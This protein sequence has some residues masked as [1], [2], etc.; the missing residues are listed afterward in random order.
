MAGKVKNESDN[1]EVKQSE[2]IVVDLS[3][4]KQDESVTNLSAEDQEKIK[5]ISEKLREELGLNEQEEKKEEEE[6]DDYYS[7]FYKKYSKK[8]ENVDTTSFGKYDSDLDF[9]INKKVRR[10][11]LPLPKKTKVLFGALAGVF[12]IMFAAVLGVVLYKPPV[13]VYISGVAI[14]QRVDSV[15]GCYVVDDN[16]LGQKLS[17]DSVYINCTYS[18]GSVKKVQITE[19]MTKI[20]TS[21]AINSR[22]EFVREGDV[23]VEVKY[24]GKTMILRFVVEANPPV[25]MTLFS[26]NNNTKTFDISQSATTWQIDN[27]IVV[28]ITYQDGTTKQV[29]VND[30]R[31]LIDGKSPTVSNGIMQIPA[32]LSTGGYVVRISYSETLA[33]GTVVN[34]PYQE[35]NINIVL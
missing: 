16:Y 25:S 20:L 13:P 9:K 1:E 23:D 12:V 30:C 4:D 27:K 18:D 6:A 24:A 7:R 11:H 10:V 33:D 32:G 34:V 28:N 35:F 2:D 26:A 29:S 3:G 19:D 31:Y 8:E 15:D 14:T 5:A 17:Y 22:G 21:G